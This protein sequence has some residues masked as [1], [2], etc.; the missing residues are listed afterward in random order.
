MLVKKCFTNTRPLFLL[1][2]PFCTV[3]NDNSNGGD[4]DVVCYNDGGGGVRSEI[5]EQ[6]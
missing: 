1:C 4:G 5:V 6:D 2:F 3:N